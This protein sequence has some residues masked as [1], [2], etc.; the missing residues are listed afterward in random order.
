MP[1]LVATGISKA[2]GPRV[3][4]DHVDLSVHAGERVG[5]VGINGSGKSTLCKILAGIEPRCR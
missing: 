3:L 5:I 2:F 4:L 1:I